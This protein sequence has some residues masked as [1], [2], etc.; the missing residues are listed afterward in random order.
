MWKLDF[1]GGWAP[2]NWCSW[3]MVLEKTLESPLDSVLNI[4]WKNWCWSSNTL[5][6]WCK[7][8]PTYWKRLWC[9]ER[10]KAEGERDDRRWNGWMASET[11]WH[12]FEQTLGDGKGQ[13]SLVCCSPWDHRESDM[14]EQ[15]LE[16]LE[17]QQ[18]P[19][20]FTSYILPLSLY[21][22]QTWLYCYHILHPSLPQGLCTCHFHLP[23]FSTEV[24]PTLSIMILQVKISLLWGSFLLWDQ[25]PFMFWLPL[26]PVHSLSHSWIL[27][28]GLSSL[29]EPP[30]LPGGQDSCSLSSTTVLIK[31]QMLKCHFLSSYYSPSPCH[32]CSHLSSNKEA[33][34]FSIREG[35][36]KNDSKGHVSCSYQW[37]QKK[38]SEAFLF[39]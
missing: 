30:L 9:R 7:E 12:E 8:E 14:T 22:L 32:S 6:T 39:T 38:S 26:A 31:E 13:G 20:T 2:K 23:S 37:R 5:A 19:Y 24:T 28:Q 4:H 33:Y 1:K 17:Q 3:S 21:T 35:A 34:S 16:P 27:V 15:P 29:G 10:L 25:A 18:H 11:L 36:L